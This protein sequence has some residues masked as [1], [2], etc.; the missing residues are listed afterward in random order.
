M[1]TKTITILDPVSMLGLSGRTEGYVRRAKVRFIFE[2]LFVEFSSARW[3]RQPAVWQKLGGPKAQE[4]I[5]QTFR[6]HGIDWQRGLAEDMQAQI[7]ARAEELIDQSASLSEEKRAFVVAA[8]NF[9]KQSYEAVS[10]SS[11]KWIS[12]GDVLFGAGLYAE[13]CL[14]YKN[15]SAE[16]TI[17]LDRGDL[18]FRDAK[19][20]AARM[21]YLSTSDP[22]SL[23]ERGD[24]LVEQG[25]CKFAEELYLRA[26][27]CERSDE[28]A[29]SPLPDDKVL[30]LGDY[31]FGEKLWHRLLHIFAGDAQKLTEY[32]GRAIRAGNYVA[33]AH[34]SWVALRVQDPSLEALEELEFKEDMWMQDFNKNL[35]RRVDELE[36]S[37]RSQNSLENAGIEFIWELVERTEGEMLKTKNFGRKSLAEI[38]EVLWDLNLSLGMKLH[39]F[40]KHMLS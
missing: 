32:A 6:N 26:C 2:L 24:W 35:F 28:E 5:L 36:L 9:V 16:G 39:N 4:E 38:K 33:A 15:A 40:P 7:V 37:V 19:F 25:Q 22:I 20:A 27:D 31:V 11:E 23:N 30:L 10:T 21:F 29:A 34:L 14:A 8:Q 12:F 18:V 1:S 13:A 3:Y 17:F